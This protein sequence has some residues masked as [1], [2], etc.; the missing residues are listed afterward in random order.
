MGGSDIV[1]EEVRLGPEAHEHLDCPPQERR[2]LE[3]HLDEAATMRPHTFC[4]ECGK[5]KNLSGAR[6]KRV[7][8]YLSGL[9]TLKEYLERGAK[10]V[11]MTQSQSGLIAR[12]L[13]DLREFEDRY[14]LSLEVQL[15]LYVEA[16]RSVRPDLDDELIL[17]LLPKV[18]KK[19]KKPLIEMMGMVAAT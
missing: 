13:M 14:G 17:R 15:Q 18:K 16:V 4:V 1:M 10:R 9:S 3:S 12:S 6:A 11:R 5:V 2:W 7:G 19:P 8:F